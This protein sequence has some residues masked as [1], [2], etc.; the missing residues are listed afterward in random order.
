M[1]LLTVASGI[2]KLRCGE[3][4]CPESGFHNT[5]NARGARVVDEGLKRYLAVAS[6]SL[7]LPDAPGFGFPPLFC[8]LSFPSRST[9]AIIHGP[10]TSIGPHVDTT[11]T[12]NDIEQSHDGDNHQR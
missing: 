12:T 11:T 4:G 10:L 1:S 5:G 9:V 6:T 7:R 8:E 3:T 2:L